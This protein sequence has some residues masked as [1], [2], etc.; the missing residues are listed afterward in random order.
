MLVEKS[1]KCCSYWGLSVFIIAYSMLGKPAEL[2]NSTLEQH[3]KYME[4]GLQKQHRFRDSVGPQPR[5]LSECEAT[6]RNC[7]IKLMML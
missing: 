6:S 2:G 4:S 1:L 3:N 7:I 5:S